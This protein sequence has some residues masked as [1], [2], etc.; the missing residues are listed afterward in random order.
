[1][2]RASILAVL[3]VVALPLIASAHKVWIRPSQT[4]LSGNDPWVTFD[5]AVS[6]DLFFFNHFPLR[7]DNLV[8]TAPDGSQVEAENQATGK[9]RSVFDLQLAQQGTYRVSVI[10]DGLFASWEADG[11]RKRWRGSVDA[12]ASEVPAN[13]TNL[14]VTQNFSRVET[15]VTNGQPNDA[16]LK[17]SGKGIELISLSHPN[18]QYAGEEARF[19]V[20]VEGKPAEGLEFEIIRGGIRY[21]NAQEETLVTTDANGEFAV[22]W[23]EPG[24]YW[25]ETSSS[26]EK[27]TVAEASSRR[28]SYVGTLEVLPQ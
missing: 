25:L 11:E 3:F 16:A 12:F 23:K 22:T 15:Y 17:P 5:A 13:A 27:T 18:D 19:R 21:R 20:L 2:K 7:L 26:D 28:L 9:Y 8:I 10:N 6:N 1:M 14:K 4:V 24:M